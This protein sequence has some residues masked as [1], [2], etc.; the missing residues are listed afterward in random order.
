MVPAPI[1]AITAASASPGATALPHR[2]PVFQVER[3]DRMPGRFTGP[4]DHIAGNGLLDFPLLEEQDRQIGMIGPYIYQSL[5]R[6]NQGRHSLQTHTE[7]H[8]ATPSD[9]HSKM[10]F[11]ASSR[12]VTSRQPKHRSLSHRQNAVRYFRIKARAWRTISRPTG[13][14]Q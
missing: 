13:L 5:A 3:P 8:R 12:L 2:D 11:R 10:N 4:R 9:S 14:L 6:G 1:P 7:I